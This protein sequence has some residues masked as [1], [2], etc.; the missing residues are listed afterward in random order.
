[1]RYDF[2]YDLLGRLTD[3]NYGGSNS[4]TT[5]AHSRTYGYDL[6]G[7]MTGRDAKEGAD[8]YQGAWLEWTWN[9]GN[10]NRP[11][12]WHQQRTLSA[13]Y[14][15]QYPSGTA[16]VADAGYAYDG[17]GNRTAELDGQGDTLSVVRYN[18]LNLPEEYVSSSG[19]TVRYVYSADGEKLYVQQTAPSN[20]TQ[21]TEYAANYRIDNGT[22]SMIHTDAGYYTPM[23]PGGSG[24]EH[25][26][27]LK[28][29]L[30]NTRVLASGRGASLASYHYDPFGESI[31]VILNPP[32]IFFPYDAK[33]SPYRYGGKEWNATTSTYDFEARY[34]SPSFHRFTT[35]DP[36]CEKYYGISP[37]AYCANDPVNLVDPS[38]ESTWVYQVED[39]TYRV[40]NGDLEDNDLNV[41]VYTKDSSGDYTIRGESIGV[42]PTLRSFYNSD[43]SSWMAEAVIRMDDN[44]G[45]EFMNYV[46]DSNVSLMGYMMN[47]VPNGIFDFK[48][49]NGSFGVIYNDVKDFYR[50]MPIGSIANGAAMIAS[51]RDIGNMVAGYVAGI[52]GISWSAA[53]TAFDTLELLQQKGAK[54][55][56][57]NST[58]DAQ[59]YGW[60]IGY[61]RYRKNP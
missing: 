34:L 55:K 12:T 8:L 37:Y 33:E 52:R 9:M 51:A 4:S 26:W 23:L 18:L 19:E 50:G 54:T 17:M 15:P 36:L 41:Y 2:G 39:G 44:S 53:R 13:Q 24:H 16:Q 10:G 49:T 48:K 42:T 32:S 5:L 47:A 1:M 58:Q 30:G 61:L 3:A 21:G 20:V 60:S 38:G 59:K 43:R 45:K 14:N 31:D 46:V 25:V 11:G 29:H 56:E 40:F 7:N 35:M 27:S 6:N 57:G 22:I 28:D